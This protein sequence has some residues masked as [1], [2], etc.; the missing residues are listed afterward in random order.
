MLQ[1]GPGLAVFMPVAYSY[2]SGDD[3]FLQQVDEVPDPVI[4]NLLAKVSR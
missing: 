1:G 2:I 3:K 4:G